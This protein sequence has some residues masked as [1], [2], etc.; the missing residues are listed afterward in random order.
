LI[1]GAVALFGLKGANGIRLDGGDPISL[2][3]SPK[4]A[5]IAALTPKIIK[6]GKITRLLNFRLRIRKKIISVLE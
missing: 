6:R 2:K 5:P 3:K 4:L 1:G